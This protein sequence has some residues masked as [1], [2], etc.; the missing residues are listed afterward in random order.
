[1]SVQ[2]R[3]KKYHYR[4]RLKEHRFSGVCENC[5]T[6]KD[7][8]KFEEQVYAEKLK[9]YEALQREKKRI[10]QNKTI[11]ALVEN[12]K[13]ELSGGRQ[14]LLEEGMRPMS[15]MSEAFPVS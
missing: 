1:M 3:G 11:V 9:E 10:R 4:F 2:L 6:E 13:L 15:Y 14:I 5:T 12:Y 8:L 7:A